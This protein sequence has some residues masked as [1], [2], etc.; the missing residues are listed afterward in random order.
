[1]NL[2]LHSMPLPHLQILALHNGVKLHR[3][4][5][6]RLPYTRKMLIDKIHRQWRKQGRTLSSPNYTELANVHALDVNKDSAM[7]YIQLAAL[8]RGIPIF[9][10]LSYVPRKKTSILYD[11]TKKKDN[12]Q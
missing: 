9:K 5:G 12:D 7:I 3:P 2:N 1:M 4:K 8:V 10:P 11:V 6:T